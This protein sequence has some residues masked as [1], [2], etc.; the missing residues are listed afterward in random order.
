MKKPK[1][2]SSDKGV[3]GKS[4][5]PVAIEGTTSMEG[6]VRTLRRP[7]P[8]PVDTLLDLVVDRLTN[9]VATVAATLHKE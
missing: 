5:A 1:N 2:H 7:L 6:A 3:R 9:D 8:P 4:L